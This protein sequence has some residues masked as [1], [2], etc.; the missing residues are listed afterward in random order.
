MTYII[1]KLTS[2]KKKCQWISSFPRMAMAL[3]K[4]LSAW[5]P[6]QNRSMATLQE[7]FTKHAGIWDT[8]RVTLSALPEPRLLGRWARQLPPR[9]GR[10]Q[11]DMCLLLFLWTGKSHE[12]TFHRSKARWW[13][14]TSCDLSIS[15]QAAPEKREPGRKEFASS[16]YKSHWRANGPKVQSSKG[17]TLVRLGTKA[18]HP[19]TTQARPKQKGHV[20]VSSFHGSLSEMESDKNENCSIYQYLAHSYM[21]LKLHGNVCCM[22][23]WTTGQELR[24]ELQQLAGSCPEM[25]LRSR[26]FPCHTRCYPDACVVAAGRGGRRLRWPLAGPSSWSWSRWKNSSRRCDLHVQTWDPSGFL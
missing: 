3:M 21:H 6:K 20:S 23:C 16:K 25:M 19:S 5:A 8:R 7:I 18:S 17:H 22:I 1:S 24:D 15:W 11:Q 26:V 10:S 12:V 4:Y 14:V 13:L 2:L 9:P